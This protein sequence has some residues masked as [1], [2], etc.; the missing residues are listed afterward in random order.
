[1]SITLQPKKR[2]RDFAGCPPACPG[3]RLTFFHP[4]GV[5][6]EARVSIPP[7]ESAAGILR[8]S[9]HRSLFSRLEGED[10]DRRQPGGILHRRN[11]SPTLH[12]RE[13]RF[14]LTRERLN[15]SLDEHEHSEK[16]PTEESRRPVSRPAGPRALSWQAAR[17]QTWPSESMSGPR[18]SSKLSSGNEHRR[19]SD[20]RH[21][22]GRRMKFVLD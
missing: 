16:P 9:R 15:N 19:R 4:R 11:R 12:A 6:H 17:S 20:P 22:A 2:S 8:H 21:P 18:R 1:V 5:P 14:D 13:E 10:S 7:C 3:G